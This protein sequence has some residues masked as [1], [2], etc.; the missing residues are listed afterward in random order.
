MK[1]PEIKI[2]VS[3][4]EGDK[5]KIGSPDDA[6]NI[7]SMLFDKNTIAWQEEV[8]LLSLNKANEVFGWHRISK[9]GT[10]TTI[11]DPKIIFTILLNTGASGF[12]ISHNHPSGNLNPS[13][14]DLKIT[15]KLKKGGELLDIFLIDHII[16]GPENS[17]YVSLKE[18]GIL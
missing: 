13:E 17:N 15:Q 12:I 8:I 5:I 10:T 2:K 3:L 16:M 6:N 4:K 7:L 11:M 9:G 18:K 1:I 14:Q